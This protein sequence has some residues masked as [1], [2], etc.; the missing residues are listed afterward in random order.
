MI[1]GKNHG[2]KKRKREKMFQRHSFPAPQHQ[3]QSMPGL[4]MKM[5]LVMMAEQALRTKSKTRHNN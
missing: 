3:M 1:P 5:N 4:M 2:R